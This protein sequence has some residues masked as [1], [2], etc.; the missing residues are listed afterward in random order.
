[1]AKTTIGVVVGRFQ[2]PVLSQGHKDLLNSVMEMSDRLVILLGVSTL[3]GRTRE[4][5]LTF[6]QRAP[7][8]DEY[9]GTTILPIFNQVDD[10]TWSKSLDS[11]ISDLFADSTITLFGGRDS[12]ASAYSGKFPVK[13]LAFSASAAIEGRQIRSAIKEARDQGFLRGQIYSLSYQ[14]PKTYPTVDIAVI[15]DTKLL[16]IQRTD[17][18]Q[19]TLPGGFVDPTDSSLEAAAKRELSEEMGLTGS[20]RAEYVGSTLIDDWRYRGTRDKIMTSLFVINYTFG[21]PTPNP[22]EV[23]DYKWVKVLEALKIIAPHHD[24]LIRLLITNHLL[25]DDDLISKASE[26]Y[27]TL[28]G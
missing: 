6:S 16:L 13:T 3:D 19:W 11:L 28:R 4:N 10:K 5:P 8:F 23:Q 1:M 17:T 27:R 9:P 14:Y 26:D 7:L 2:V 20:G 15:R 18:S 24:P 12:F 22:L 25:S 21:S